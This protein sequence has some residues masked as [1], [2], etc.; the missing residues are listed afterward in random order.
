MQT[1]E[2]SHQE[3]SARAALRT[4]AGLIEDRSSD[5]DCVREISYLLSLSGCRVRYRPLKEPGG[6]EM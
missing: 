3:R 2:E 1:T 5:A 4:I 6:P